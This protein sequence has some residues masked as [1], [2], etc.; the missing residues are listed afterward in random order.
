M[1]RHVHVCLNEARRMEEFDRGTMVMSFSGRIQIVRSSQKKIVHFYI[2][3]L[4]K[5]RTVR[6]LQYGGT[7]PHGRMCYYL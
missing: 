5:Y 7:G 2:Q 4:K 1:L 6:K 3:V